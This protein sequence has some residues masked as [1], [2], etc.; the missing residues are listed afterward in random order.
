[1]I[2]EDELERQLRIKRTIYDARYR[3]YVTQEVN[4][5]TESPIDLDDDEV[6]TYEPHGNIEYSIVFENRHERRKAAAMVRKNSKPRSNHA[7]NRFNGK[8][9]KR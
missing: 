4:T 1:M 7:S 5:T 6:I 9:R 8:G 2:N 3:N